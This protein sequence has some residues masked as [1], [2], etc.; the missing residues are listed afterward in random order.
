[1][2]P[3]SCWTKVPSLSSLLIFSVTQGFIC[4]TVKLLIFFFFF[5]CGVVRTQTSDN[6]FI[7]KTVVTD[8]VQCDFCQVLIVYNEWPL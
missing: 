6:T 1:M 2:Y 5:S 3:E 4:G 7:R 8:F